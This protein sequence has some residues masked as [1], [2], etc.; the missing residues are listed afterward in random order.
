MRN[1]RMYQEFLELVTIDCASGKETPIAEKLKAKLTEL[2]FTVTQDQA[3]ETFGG[4]CGNVYAV[5]EGE[6]G[7]SLMFSSHM[8]RVP[9]GLG[10]HPVE[11][12]GVLYSDGSTILARK[13]ACMEP[14]Q[15]T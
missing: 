7:G 15:R 6:L 1:E 3:G 13:P 9:N 8:D 11:K 4:E 14:P 10:I 12:D 5:R 2:G